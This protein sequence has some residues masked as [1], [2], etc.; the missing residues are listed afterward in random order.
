MT[1]KKTKITASGDAPVGRQPL[2]VI[3]KS[4]MENCYS[5]SD[6]IDGMARAFASFSSGGCYVPHRYVTRSP[7]GALSLLFKPAFP[8]HNDKFSCKFITQKNDGGMPGIPTILGVV[9]LLDSTTGEIVS[10][11]DGDFITAIRTGAASGLATKLLA[12]EDSRTLAVFGCGGQGRTQ[13]EAVD[14]VRDLEQVWVFDSSRERAEAF[15]ED[16]GHKTKANIEFA[17]DLFTLKDADVICTAT[18]AKSPLFRRDHLKTG[19]HINAIGSYT[20]EMQ[21]LDPVVIKSGRSYFDDMESCLTESGDYIR[22]IVNPVAAGD[23]I[24]GE[25]GDCVLGRAP[26]RI[27]PDETTIFKSVGTAIQDF[28]VA[29]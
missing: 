22:S 8:H 10:I 14:A 26:G 9:L 23:H 24:V 2:K 18:S 3:K 15:I 6:A 29:D 16:M 5:M 4:E 19:V 25:I 13:L 27:S 21:E 7:D 1:N 17:S 28:V 20:P 11:M 12:R